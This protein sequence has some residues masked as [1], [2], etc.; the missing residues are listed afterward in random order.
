MVRS[1]PLKE[2]PFLSKLPLDRRGLLQLDLTTVELKR[3]EVFPKQGKWVLHLSAS[4]EMDDSFLASLE[5]LLKAQVPEIKKVEW[6][7][8]LA[9]QIMTL[10]ALCETHWKEI[11]QDIT[12]LLPTMK[13]WLGEARYEVA[14]DELRLFVPNALGIEYLGQTTCC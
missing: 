8:E 1:L 14:K 6:C 3:V 7:V 5:S 4:P 10:A 13:G 9:Q 12:D 11:V 2:V